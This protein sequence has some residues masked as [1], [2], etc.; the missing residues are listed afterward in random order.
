MTTLNAHLPS[1]AI[2]GV[3]HHL[4]TTFEDNVSLCAKLGGEVT[5]QSQ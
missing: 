1:V 2:V 4:P 3:G 5:A